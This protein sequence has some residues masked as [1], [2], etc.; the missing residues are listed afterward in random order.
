M[1][2]NTKAMFFL[3]TFIFCLHFLCAQQ[4]D[5]D[6]VEDDE[7]E[8]PHQSVFWYVSMCVYSTFFS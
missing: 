2:A 4:E 7:D 8:A 6:E 1:G 5:D 3:Q